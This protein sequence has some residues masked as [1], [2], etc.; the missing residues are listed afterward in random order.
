MDKM[1]HIFL[2]KESFEIKTFLWDTL[3][4]KDYNREV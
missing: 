3:A 4:T 1:A 2:L